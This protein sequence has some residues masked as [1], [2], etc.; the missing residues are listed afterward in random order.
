MKMRVAQVRWQDQEQAEGEPLLDGLGDP[1]GGFIETGMEH[2]IISLVWLTGFEHAILFAGLGRQ[3]C[4]G[5]S[6]HYSSWPYIY[7]YGN[8]GT[9]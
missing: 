4:D 8:I 5:S 1:G 6:V 2:A 9:L 7:V 3:E